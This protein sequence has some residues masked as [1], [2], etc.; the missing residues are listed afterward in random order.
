MNTGAV[1]VFDDN[2]PSPTQL[3]AL[4][5]DRVATVPRLRQ[6]VHRPRLGGGLPV[7]VD[8]PGFTLEDHLVRREH[9]DKPTG[10]RCWTLRP[11]WSA[12]GCPSPVH[13]GGPTWSSTRPP[14]W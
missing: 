5:S 9:E 1:L 14:A 10:P 3:Q 4:L 12:S 11:R 13:R 6:R 2:G 8:N 7:W